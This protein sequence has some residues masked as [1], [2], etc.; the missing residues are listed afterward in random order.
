MQE[1]D[2]PPMA[3]VLF[4]GEYDQRRDQVQPDTPD[5]LPPMPPTARATGWGSPSGCCCPSIR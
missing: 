2:E 3:Y 5:V 4:R 1:R